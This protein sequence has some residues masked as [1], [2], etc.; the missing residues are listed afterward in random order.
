MIIQAL[1]F[2]CLVFSSGQR[3]QED[4]GKDRDDR[5]DDEKL[6]ERESRAVFQRRLFQVGLLSMIRT[7]YLSSRAEFI[8]S[9]LNRRQTRN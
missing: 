6:D 1:Y 2:L 7:F 8:L 9:E 5:D 4:A 3:G